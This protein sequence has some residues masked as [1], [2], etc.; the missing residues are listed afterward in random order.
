MD[1]FLPVLVVICLLAAIY[2][3]WQSARQRKAAGLPGGQVVYT[4]TSQWMK[5][6]KPLYAASLGLTGKPDYLV[7]QGEVFIPVEVKS[8]RNPNPNPYDAHIYQLAA[9]CIL[10]TQVYGKRP[11]H[12][13]L[14]YTHKSQPGRSFTIPFTP[15]LEAD[16][17]QVIHEIQAQPLH[18]EVDRSHDSARRCQGCGFRDQC[19]QALG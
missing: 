11:A 16:V 3:M 1:L 19:D 15:Q 9:Y 7:Q 13:I 8:S 14:H 6:E 10:V 12:G 17:M 18:Q 4:D 2:L 5:V